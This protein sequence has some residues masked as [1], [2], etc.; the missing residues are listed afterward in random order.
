MDGADRDEVGAVLGVEAVKIGLVLEVVCVERA[1]GQSLVRQ[2]VVVI[3]DDLE[4]VAFVGEGLLDLLEDLGVRGGAGADGDDFVIGR[5][6]V[7]VVG[8]LAAAGTQCDERERQ[9]EGEDERRDLFHGSFSFIF[10]FLEFVWF[11]MIECAVY[12]WHIRPRRMFTRNS[13]G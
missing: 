5:G 12:Q 7:L 3:G 13:A 2:D 8:G 10:L 4:L 1:V 6:G 9:H 11:R